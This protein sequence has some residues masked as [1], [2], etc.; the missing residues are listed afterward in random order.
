MN[1][2]LAALDPIETS[3]LRRDPITGEEGHLLS[4]LLPYD[5]VVKTKT[6]LKDGLNEYLLLLTAV[7]Q[8]IERVHARDWKSFD[9]LV[10]ENACQIRA[11]RLAMIASNT[12][13]DLEN[14]L[15][16]ISTAKTL[17]EN[18]LAHFSKVNSKKTS[19][20]DFLNQESAEVR[21]NEDE[22]FLVKAYILTRTKV[23][24]PFDPEK[25]LVLNERTDEKKIKEIY[26]VGA[27]FARSFISF[28]RKNLSQSSVDFVKKIAKQSESDV[29]LISVLEDFETKHKDL[30]CLPCYWTTKALLDQALHHRIPI[31]LIAQ[32]K[33]K[34]RNYEETQKVTLFFEVTPDGYMQTNRESLDPRTPALV[35]LGNSCEKHSLLPDRE[36]WVEQL[37]EHSPVDLFLAYAAAHRQYPDQSKDTLLSSLSDQDYKYHKE[38]SEKWGCSLDNPSRFF[39]AHAFCDEIGNIETKNS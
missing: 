34:D 36:L 5:P 11:V 8:T 31:V 1:S 12:R 2:Q 24:K 20:K 33:A 37:L 21:L 7:E 28:L 25:A 9:P 14:L 29:S 4:D 39:L 27:L 30:H 22:Y 16:R 38:Q 6:R 23:R 13:F 10:G 3:L 17:F 26:P 35:L 19:L 15:G 32:Q 18:V